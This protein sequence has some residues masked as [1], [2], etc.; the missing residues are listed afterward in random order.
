MRLPK[1]CLNIIIIE[2]RAGRRAQNSFASNSNLLRKGFTK[3][4]FIL[5]LEQEAVEEELGAVF[6]DLN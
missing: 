5:F 6:E 1:L 2:L 4:E 3:Q